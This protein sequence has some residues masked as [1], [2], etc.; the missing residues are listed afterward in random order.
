MDRNTGRSHIL[1]GYPDIFTGDALILND[2][3]VIGETSGQRRA[4]RLYRDPALK[5]HGK[6]C[7]GVPRAAGKKLRPGA[8]AVFGDGA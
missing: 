7:L 5:A 6:G 8:R 4:P 2:T 1:F 3:K